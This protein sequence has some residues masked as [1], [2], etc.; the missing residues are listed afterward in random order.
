MYTIYASNVDEEVDVSD[1]DKLFKGS[2]HQEYGF[3]PA[4]VERW[5]G[6]STGDT[7]AKTWNQPKLKVDNLVD[8]AG[9]SF[10]GITQG[11]SPLARQFLIDAMKDAM[12]TE[13]D[14]LIAAKRILPIKT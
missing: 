7:R 14:R 2:F 1:P 12:P 10:L 6:G 11:D 4:V 9:Y 5:L 8:I 3:I 13:E